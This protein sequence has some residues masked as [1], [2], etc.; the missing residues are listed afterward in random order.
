MVFSRGI[1]AEGWLV[2]IVMHRPRSAGATS[3][4]DAAGAAAAAARLRLSASMGEG[5][6]PCSKAAA[7]F[8]AF[9]RGPT[10]A[11]GWLCDIVPERCRSGGAELGANL[12]LSA[13]TLDAMPRVSGLQPGSSALLG[14]V[15]GL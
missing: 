11:E 9:P 5:N 1:F 6:C 8:D 3:D 12:A 2:L 7:N 13:A 14:S 10:F 15:V 4:D